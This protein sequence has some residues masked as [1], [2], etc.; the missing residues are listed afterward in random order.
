M[1]DFPK[2]QML[3][4]GVKGRHAHVDSWNRNACS[5]LLKLRAAYSLY[6]AVS[7]RTTWRQLIALVRAQLGPDALSADEEEEAGAGAQSVMSPISRILRPRRV[8]FKSKS[9]SLA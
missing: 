3:S 4:T 5:D 6:R 7:C 9:P 2:G 1:T 8:W